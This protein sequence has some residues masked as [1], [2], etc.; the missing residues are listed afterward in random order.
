MALLMWP[1]EYYWIN[2]K[3]YLIIRYSEIG[4]YLNTVQMLFND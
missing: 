2:L 1:T 4:Y 3:K